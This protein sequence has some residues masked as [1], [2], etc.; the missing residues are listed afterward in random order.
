MA[1]NP[2]NL[3]ASKSPNHTDLKFPGNFNFV[4]AMRYCSKLPQLYKSACMILQQ[5]PQDARL[6]YNS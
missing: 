3:N 4:L 6:F 2:R 5:A 1:V